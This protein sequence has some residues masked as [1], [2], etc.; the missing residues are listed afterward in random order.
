[1]SAHF[2]RWEFKCPHCGVALV[3]PRLLEALERLRSYRSK[4]IIIVSGY[5][6]PVHNEKVGGARDSQHMYAAAA[7]VPEGS[8]SLDEARAAGFTGIGLKH[9]QPTHVDVRDGSLVTWNYPD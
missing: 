7:D 4:P 8:C 1:V 2:Q 3:R 5:R 6:C 9:G